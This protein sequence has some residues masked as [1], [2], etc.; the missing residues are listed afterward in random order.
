MVG[1]G[2]RR[3]LLIFYRRT[4]VN[5]QTAFEEAMGLIDHHH[6]DLQMTLI[7]RAHGQR[8]RTIVVALG[9]DS[10]HVHTVGNPPPASFH[11]HT[12]TRQQLMDAVASP[13]LNAAPVGKAVQVACLRLHAFY[14]LTHKFKDGGR[15][16]REDAYNALLYQPFDDGDDFFHLAQNVGPEG[17]RRVYALDTLE[18]LPVDE[19][20][21]RENPFTR[22]LFDMRN[23]RK[24]RF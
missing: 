9:Q 18:R 21:T 7:W 20:G 5:D 4:P 17:V 10:F 1:T 24:A 6:R 3:E 23:L 8:V 16:T 19:W 12:H 13:F 11:A 15:V 14:E 2:N 22:E